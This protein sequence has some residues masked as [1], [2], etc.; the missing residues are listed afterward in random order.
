MEPGSIRVERLAETVKIAKLAF[1]AE[2]VFFD[3]EHY[4]VTGYR[5]YPK[6][7]QEPRPPLLV[8][9]GGRRVLSLAAAGAEIVGVMPVAVAAGGMRATQ[10][11]LKS[12]TEKC[13]WI[14]AAAGD[15][16]RDLEINILVLGVIVTTNRR[17]AAEAHLDWLRHSP[18]FALDGELTVDDLLTSPYLAYGTEQQ[19]VE[20]FM[21]IRAETGASYFA[22]PTSHQ[23]VFAPI[24]APSG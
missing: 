1:E 24:N 6:P 12:V 10:L 7:R 4:K 2:T 5:P 17:A 16:W 3:G 13:A 9:G 21:H 14:R 8:G 20:H 15:R 23:D 19:I 18:F 11:T 22:V